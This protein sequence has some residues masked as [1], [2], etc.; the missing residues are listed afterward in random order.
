[1][2]NHL[3]LLVQAK[4]NEVI[5]ELEKEF[6]S[7]TTR[8]IL[9]A[10]DTEPDARK[11]WMME[12]F[13]N[14]GNILGFLRKFHVWQTCTNPVFINCHKK[15]TLLEYI[16]FIHGNPVR[17]RIVDTSTDYLYS[18][19]R[20]YSGMTGLVNITKIP[21]IEQQL[22]HADTTGSFFGKFIHN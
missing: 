7:F 20:D 6:K 4:E 19:A 15:D 14:F 5:A 16:D 8:K 1:M 12:R 2:T 17:D 9:E 10:I 22:I 21:N 3:H 18:S 13:E 11:K